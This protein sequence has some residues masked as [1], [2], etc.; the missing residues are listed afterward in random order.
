MLT[1]QT[2]GSAESLGLLLEQ[3]YGVTV[4]KSIID[5]HTVLQLL[6][7]ADKY[8]VK[9]ILSHCTCLCVVNLASQLVHGVAHCCLQQHPVPQL[10]QSV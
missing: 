5:A 10:V 3:M 9:E 7:I 6:L 4:V 8:D 1:L 2:Q